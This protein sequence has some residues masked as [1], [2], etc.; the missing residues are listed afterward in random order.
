[1][2]HNVDESYEELRNSWG[3]RKAPRCA[4]EIEVVEGDKSECHRVGD[5][6]KYPED[7]GL[8]CPFLLNSMDGMIRVLEFGGSFP[9]D[10]KG[11]PYE[12]VTD[13]DGVSTEFV[14]CPDPSE[15]GIVVKITRTKLP[16]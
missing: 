12:K 15:V 6:F 5:K 1:M 10:Y 2:S 14:R 9:W 13:P 3:Y 8:I 4:I 11:T 16:D 7:R